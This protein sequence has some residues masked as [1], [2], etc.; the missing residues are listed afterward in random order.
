MMI[1]NN[2]QGIKSHYNNDRTATA[3]TDYIGRV[4]KDSLATDLAKSRYYACLNDG[5]T[6][7]TVIE[8]EMVYVLFLYEG[9]PT[10]KYFSI[11]SVKS[12][13][14]EGVKD[15]IQEAFNRFGIT[16]YIKI[17]WS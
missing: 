14:A 1:K 13:D 15:S 9:T 4:V 17:T 2:I 3:F 6:D 10:V 7:S 8:Q 16:S 5:S 12:A 11:E